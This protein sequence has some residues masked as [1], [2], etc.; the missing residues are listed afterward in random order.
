MKGVSTFSPQAIEILRL[1]VKK[2]SQDNNANDQKMIRT[3]MRKLGFYVSDYGIQNITTTIFEDL[4]SA[5]QRI[6]RFF[7]FEPDK[8]LCGQL[9]ILTSQAI[10]DMGRLDQC[11]PL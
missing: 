2:Y 3:K 5:P 9:P 7:G 4:L 8:S 6:C 10:R 1:L 11:D